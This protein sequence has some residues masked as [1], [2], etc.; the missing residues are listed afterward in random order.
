MSSK[1]SGKQINKLTSVLAEHARQR[2]LKD[3]KESSCISSTRVAVILLREHGI[4][5]NPFPVKVNIFNPLLSDLLATEVQINRQ[6]GFDD[7]PDL[8]RLSETPGTWSV[9]LGYETPRGGWPGHLVC[10]IDNK[11]CLDLSLDQ[12]SRPHHDMLLTPTVFETTRGFMKGEEASVCIVNRCV[13]RY[14]ADLAN[15]EYLTARDW[16]DI[17]RLQGILGDMRPLLRAALNGH[18]S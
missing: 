9:G 13:V 1:L 7:D 15:G 10:A 2:I 3:F 6:A 14:T 8:I 17:G 12:A 5:A 4:K 11:L 16:T 18:G